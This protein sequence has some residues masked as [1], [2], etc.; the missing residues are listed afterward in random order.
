[1]PVVHIEG[2]MEKG[3]SRER[4][5]G[6]TGRI[7]QR[8]I[9]VRQAA[10]GVHFLAIQ[11]TQKLQQFFINVRNARNARWGGSGRKI[12]FW[13]SGDIEARTKMKLPIVPILMPENARKCPTMF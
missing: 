10:A 4:E 12:F 1:M 9:L 11:V 13:E 3:G 5:A 7:G 6:E 8:V 2:R